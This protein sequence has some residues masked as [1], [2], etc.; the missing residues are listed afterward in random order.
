MTDREDRMFVTTLQLRD[1]DTS[2]RHPYTYLEGRAVPYDVFADVG[3]FLEQHESG[4]FTDTTK[5]G[6][7][8]N[9]PLLL[10]HD[11]RSF[12]IGKAESWSH[13]DGA[14]DGVWKLNDSPHSQQ[15][16]R[17]AHDGEL[18]GMSVGFVPMRFSVERCED[19][20]GRDWNPDL[21]AEHKDRWTRHENRLVEVSL[22]PAPVYEDSGVVL[23]RSFDWQAERRAFGG[24]RRFPEVEAWRAEVDALRSAQS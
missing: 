19:W 13:D 20:S 7:G 14:L 17:A 23:V 16:A 1:V 3:P 18:I 21:G 8:K 4:S 15:A 2:G 12:P 10:F 24:G 11:K 5:R 22:T 9:A 6:T